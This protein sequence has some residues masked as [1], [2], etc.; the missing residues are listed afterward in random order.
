MLTFLPV[1]KSSLEHSLYGISPQEG[2]RQFLS[3]GLRNETSHNIMIYFGLSLIFLYAF[4][5][6]K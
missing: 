5:T 3:L 6:F 4:E 2:C 1:P